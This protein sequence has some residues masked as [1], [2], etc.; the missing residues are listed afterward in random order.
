MSEIF[1]VESELD[2]QQRLATAGDLLVI[3]EFFVPWS[4][5]CK[6]LDSKLA[7]FAEK[8]SGRVRILKVDT[9]KLKQL[10]LRNKVRYVPTFVFFWSGEKLDGI[11][12]EAN[13]RKVEGYIER[14][15]AS[16]SC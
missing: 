14:Y 12:D 2:F 5:S 13:A 3:V 6:K 1:E 7:E 16:T 15:L 11:V 9:D 4:G 10:T 8:Y